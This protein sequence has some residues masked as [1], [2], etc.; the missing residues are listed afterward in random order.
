MTLHSNTLDEG[1]R[2]DVVDLL[3]KRSELQANL[4]DNGEVEEWWAMVGLS[5]DFSL[6]EPFGGFARHGF[7]P[8][9]EHLAALAANFRN[10]SCTLE[11]QQSYASEDMMVLVYI[12]RQ[13]GEV[14][15]LP[16]Q[17]WSLRV[18]QVFRRNGMGWDLVHRHADPLVRSIDLDVTAALASGRQVATMVESG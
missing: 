3:V 14:R 15:G 13:T 2:A 18:T 10:G 5:P 6:F 16:N 12:E 7:D 9:P 17:D 4:F 1:A 8:T 11:L